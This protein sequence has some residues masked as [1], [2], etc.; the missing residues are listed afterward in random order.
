MTS[1]LSVFWRSEPEK[2]CTSLSSRLSLRLP[3]FFTGQKTV[4]P[5]R[6]LTEI[7]KRVR[8]RKPLNFQRF[9]VPTV[10]VPSVGGRR[11]GSSRS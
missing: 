8:T 6:R 11:K 2:I 7:L 10:D 9:H 5:E 4:D 3:T 1:L